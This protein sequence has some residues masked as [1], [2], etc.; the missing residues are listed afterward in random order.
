MPISYSSTPVSD[1]LGGGLQNLYSLTSKGLH[2]RSEE[3]CLEYFPVIRVG[4]E[5]ILEQTIEDRA[6]RKKLDGVS[7]A[8]NKRSGG[9][10]QVRCCQMEGLTKPDVFLYSKPTAEF[11]WCQWTFVSFRVSITL[12]LISIY[13]QRSPCKGS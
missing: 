1:R 9:S 7:R 10:D 6:R 3:E 11:T 13:L 8:L 4:I 2:E 12:L 5:L